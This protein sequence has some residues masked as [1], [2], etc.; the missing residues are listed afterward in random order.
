MFPL[1][2]A[3]RIPR[4]IDVTLPIRPGMLTYPGDPVVS[5][6]RTSD[7]QHGDVSNL[8][9]I[10]MSTHTGTHVDPPLHFVDGGAPIDRVP[11]DTLVGEALVVDMR[12]H[13]EIGATELER[14]E[15]PADVTRLLF[16]TDWSARW[17]EAAAAFPNDATCVTAEGAGWLISRGIRLV[18]TDFLSIEAADDPAFPVHRG[19]LGA[20]VVIVEGLDLRDVPAGR[21]TLWCLPLRILDGD[22]GPARAVLVAD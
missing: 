16:L 22:G 1:A 4:I 17:G 5:V 10:S 11:L 9:V 3:D 6:E 21:Y 19:L 14:L 8:S 7:M 20:N 2:G 13:H 15:L 12:G 18:G